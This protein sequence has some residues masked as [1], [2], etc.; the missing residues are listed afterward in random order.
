MKSFAFSE[1][2]SQIGL[3]NK[4]DP[5]LTFFKIV[6]SFEPLNGGAPDNIINVM[7]PIAQTSHFGP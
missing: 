3:S 1:M 4:N 6:T 5:F 2:F 7:T